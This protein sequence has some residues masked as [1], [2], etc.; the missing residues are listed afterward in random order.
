[1]F[2]KHLLKE[3]AA[4]AEE[5]AAPAAEEPNAALVHS[6]TFRKVRTPSKTFENVRIPWKHVK[7]Y[8][9][10]FFQHCNDRKKSLLEGT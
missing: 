3:E 6:S 7:N 2:K 9:I 1:M 10:E 5:E 4:P 8:E